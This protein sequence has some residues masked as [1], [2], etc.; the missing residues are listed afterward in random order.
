MY[1]EVNT[2]D[3]L[4][5]QID[6]FAEPGE[7]YKFLFIAKGGGSANKSFLYQQTQGGAEPASAVE[8]PRR[9]RSAPSAP[10]LA[11]PI[12]SPIVIGGTSAEM[13]LKTVKLASCRYLDA[14]PSEGNRYGQAYRDR[15]LR[16]GGARV[17]PPARHRRAVRRQVFLP[18]RAGDPAAAA[19][20]QLA[21]RDRRLML[22]RPPDPRQDHGRGRVPRRARDKPGA[23]P[24]GN[25]D[26]AL[27]GEVVPIDLARPMAEIRQILSRYPIKTRLSLTG[28][29][30]VARDIAHAKA[31]RA[32]RSAAKG[33]PIM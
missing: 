26:A 8:V 22:G 10:P 17:D 1:E 20:R 4:P 6:L 14:L 18:R 2:G 9:R 27:G 11:R 15:G 21:D 32:A 19:R 13:N 12:T 31:Q 7:T 33:C 3:N 24:A 30:I 16:G 25:H 23:L 28:P 5:A 29:L